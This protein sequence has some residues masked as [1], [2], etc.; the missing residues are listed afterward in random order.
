MSFGVLEIFHSGKIILISSKMGPTLLSIL[1]SIFYSKLFQEVIKSGSFY[2][3][4]S[5]GSGSK[6][7][8]QA[9]LNLLKN[10]DVIKK[11]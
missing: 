1:L 8:P 2:Q 7:R 6:L 10:S 11:F 5:F 9:S 3:I 4:V